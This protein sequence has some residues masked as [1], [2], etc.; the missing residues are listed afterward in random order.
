MGVLAFSFSVACDVNIINLFM[1]FFCRET[2]VVS[3]FWVLRSAVHRSRVISRNCIHCYNSQFVH[4]LLVPS[5]CSSLRHTMSYS[6]HARMAGARLHEHAIDMYNTA[7]T[8]VL[9]RAM[10]DN[11]LKRDGDRLTIGDH[12]HVLQ[13]NVHIVAFGKAVIGMVRAAEEALGDHI[14]G[15]IASV[16]YG[17]QDTLKQL[18]KWYV[19]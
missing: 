3:S 2:M 13:H 1:L 16:P 4:S 18:G 15:G 8:S 9:P 6:L 10:V 14:V 5:C 7:V 12:S 17:I 11:A 19:A